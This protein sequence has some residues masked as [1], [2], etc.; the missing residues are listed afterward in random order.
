MR[1]NASVSAPAGKYKVTPVGEGSGTKYWR[2]TPKISRR[3]VS[4]LPARAEKRASR[5]SG[6]SH[7]TMKEIV[8]ATQDFP[9]FQTGLIT[10]G[11]VDHPTSNGFL[12]VEKGKT[13]LT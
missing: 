3:L 11:K 1:F 9:L 13:F 6:Y 12:P 5:S 7:A 10:V 2:Q 8:V 4:S